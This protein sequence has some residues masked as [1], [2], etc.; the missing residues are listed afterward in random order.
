MSDRRPPGRLVGNARCGECLLFKPSHTAF[1][2]KADGTCHLVCDECLA[3]VLR[4]RPALGE[5]FVVALLVR[6]LERALPQPD[7]SDDVA[8]R[9]AYTDAHR[10][11]LNARAARDQLLDALLD[12]EK[13]R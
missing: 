13:I 4:E 10:A 12:S 2:R 3:A 1:D 7:P 11:L 5:M 8:E 9:R 6:R